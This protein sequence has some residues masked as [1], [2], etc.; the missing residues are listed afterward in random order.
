MD[1]GSNS[2]R[3]FLA[4]LRLRASPF[5]M[6]HKTP[7]QVHRICHPLQTH[8]ILPGPDVPIFSNPEI[9]LVYLHTH[10]SVLVPLEPL[11]VL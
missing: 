8:H 9:G 11:S 7:P 4:A 5:S 2:H 10:K 6:S 1:S 3:H